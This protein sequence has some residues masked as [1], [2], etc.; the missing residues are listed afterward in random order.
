MFIQGSRKLGL[1]SRM[2][3]TMALSQPDRIRLKAT[4]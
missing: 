4:I 1:K 3:R 2:I